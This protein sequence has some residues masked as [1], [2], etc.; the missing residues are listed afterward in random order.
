LKWWAR[1]AL[2]FEKETVNNVP[3]IKSGEKGIENGSRLN[4]S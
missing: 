4:P 1:S 3:I 2:G